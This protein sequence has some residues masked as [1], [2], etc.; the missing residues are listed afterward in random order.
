ML[1]QNQEVTGTLVEATGRRTGWNG[2][3]I[4]TVRFWAVI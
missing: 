4:M 3:S 1:T 2:V